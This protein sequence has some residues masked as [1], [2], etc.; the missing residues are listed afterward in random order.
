MERPSLPISENA[1]R[2][3]D[4]HLDDDGGASIACAEKTRL[5]SEYHTKTSEFS[6]TVGILN[7]RMGVMTKDQ[8]DRIREF[9]ELARVQSENARFELERHIK[10]HGC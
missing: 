1:E 2:D 10:E 9:T 3:D 7:K 8:Y 6:R 5:V 4:S